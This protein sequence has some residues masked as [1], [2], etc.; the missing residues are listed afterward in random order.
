MARE[1]F[2]VLAASDGS[3]HA[4]TAVAAAVRFPWPA[5]STGHGVVARGAPALAGW[6]DP[7]WTALQVS[8][9]R[10]AHRTER[11]LRH[12]WPDAEA[13]VVEGAP[14]TAI[15]A[16]ARRLGARA[17]VVGSRGH[18][19][20]SRLVLG[21]TSLAVVRQAACAVLVV[22][23]RLAEVRHLV[24]GHDGSAHARHA[25][26]LVG[27]LAVPR[28]GHVTLVAVVEP[29]RAPATG[30]L[31]AAVRQAVGAEL[32]ALE[33]ERRAGAERRLDTAARVLR[34]AGWRTAATV[35]AGRPLDEL[36]AA[37]QAARPDALVVGARGTGGVA[38]LL[39]GS[40]AEGALA[41]APVPVLVVR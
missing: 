10:E 36:L 29:V 26:E 2:P 15:L 3:A 25:L 12:R 40:V 30:L 13:T 35:R 38:R 19:A 8:C 27:R 34:E 33:A 28:G 16:R 20:L 24:V 23:S 22:R 21:S 1:P 5:T 41:R 39:L 7:V 14:A 37:V 6:S 17:I 9:E 31:P 18:G 4:R 11:A 32:A